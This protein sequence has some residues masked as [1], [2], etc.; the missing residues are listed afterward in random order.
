MKKI[1]ELNTLVFI[2]LRRWPFERG[3]KADIIRAVL[4]TGVVWC[5]CVCVCDSKVCAR[6]RV[7]IV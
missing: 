5:V 2:V 6:V 4:M 1:E 7:C 3:K